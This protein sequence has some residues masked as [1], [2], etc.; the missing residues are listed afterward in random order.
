MMTYTANRSIADICALAANEKYLASELKAIYDLLLATAK[1]ELYNG[2][3]LEFNFSN[4][5]LGVS[6]AFMGPKAQFDPAGTGLI[7]V[8]RCGRR[9]TSL[10][11]SIYR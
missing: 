10:S 7:C 3:T 11:C 4:N 2:A 8:L 9:S 6:G 1:N 5:S